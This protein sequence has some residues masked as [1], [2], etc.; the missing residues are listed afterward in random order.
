MAAMASAD[1][2]APDLAPAIADLAISLAEDPILWADELL[3]VAR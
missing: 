3:G 1:Q 2:G